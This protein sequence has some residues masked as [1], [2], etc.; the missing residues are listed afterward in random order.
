MI[1]KFLWL[2]VFGLC[3]LGFSFWY[4]SPSVIIDLPWSFLLNSIE[5]N[6]TNA[7]NFSTDEWR[8]LTIIDH[9][10]LKD[11]ELYVFWNNWKLYSYWHYW[12]NNSYS[13]WYFLRFCKT[14][15]TW[16]CRD[17]WSTPYNA[18]IW[19]EFYNLTWVNFT[20]FI[21]SV[22]WET[23]DPWF[24]FY[25]ANNN[26]SYCTQVYVFWS[27]NLDWSFNIPDWKTDFTRY[28]WYS[29]FFNTNGTPEISYD[30]IYCP[31]V[32]QLIN[33]YE[34]N[35]FYSW[36][37]YSSDFIYNWSSFITW[38]SQSIFDVFSW[39]NDYLSSLEKYSTYCQSSVY[40]SNICQEAFSWEYLKLNIISKIPSVSSSIL[41]WK[42]SL[43]NYCSLFNYDLDTT[44]CVW[45]WILLEAWE[46]FSSTDVSNIIG[47][48]NYFISPSMSGSVFDNW[49]W[50]T[51]T[52]D[53]ISNLQYLFLKFTS[54]FRKQIWN[55]D[56]ILP[57]WI[58]IPFL[59][60]VLFKLF[61]K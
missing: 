50:Y 2:C 46:D 61:R 40:Q 43:Y 39:K 3:F 12:Y 35:W 44:S 21:L 41:W 49:S 33:N 4:F 28:A 19:S 53:V 47:G 56:W 48:W 58:L 32:R 20:Q 24:C 60:I 6:V 37:C 45:S 55:T 31:T 36:L 10:Q 17:E 16:F 30:N 5:N 25:N 15:W 27:F 59:L 29:P 9:W 11:N 14:Y 13:Q 52:W 8:W 7:L 26:T 57:I 1:K 18:E 38:Q 34:N 54:L 23:D 42:K 22:Q 51:Y